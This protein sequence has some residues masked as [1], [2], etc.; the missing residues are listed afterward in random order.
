MTKKKRTVQICVV[1]AVIIIAIV[2]Y[3]FLSP[4]VFAWAFARYA[5]PGLYVKSVKGRLAGPIELTGLIYNSPRQEVRIN[6]LRAN[7]SQLALFTLRFEITNLE[8]SGVQIN[9]KSVP[10]VPKKK[11]KLPQIHMP[12]IKVLIDK[13]LVQNILYVPPPSGKNKPTLINR[14]DLSAHT[15]GNTL[16]VR[17]LDMVAPRYSFAAN[18]RVQLNN[19]Y[20]ISIKMAWQMAMANTPAISGTGSIEGSLRKRLCVLQTIAPPYPVK[21]DFTATDLLGT[22]AWNGFVNWQSIKIPASGPTRLITTGRFNTNGSIKKYVFGMN[23]DLLVQNIHRH[24]RITMKGNGNRQGLHLENFSADL[25]Y[26]KM[27]ANGK[28]SWKPVKSWDFVLSATGLD[29]GQFAPAWKGNISFA[30]ATSGKIPGP[31]QRDINFLLKNLSGNLK[32]QPVSGGGQIIVK[33]K[34]YRIPRLV[35][36]L[37]KASAFASGTIGKVWKLIWRLSAAD[38][39]VLMP[40]AKGAIAA[41]GNLSGPRAKPLAVA[42]FSG[43]GIQYPGMAIKTVRANMRIDM[44]EKTASRLNATVTGAAFRGHKISLLRLSGF[45][46]PS[47]NRITLLIAGRAGKNSLSLALAGGLIKKAWDGKMERLTITE[48][49]HRTWRLK[50]TASIKAGKTEMQLKDLCIISGPS[51]ACLSADYKKGLAAE[52]PPLA[53]QAHFN[54]SRVQLALFSPLLPPGASVTGQFGVNGDIYY[55]TANGI[56]GGMDLRAQNGTMEYVLQDQAARLPFKNG[57]ITLHTAREKAGLAATLFMKADFMPSK[58][59]SAGGGLESK[60]VITMRAGQTAAHAGLRGYFRMLIPNLGLLPAIIPSV[61]NASGH[62]RA[63]INLSGTLKQPNVGGIMSLENTSLT[64]PTLGITLTNSNLTATGSGENRFLINGMFHSGKGQ[65]QLKGD[66]GFQKLKGVALNM[67]VKGQN[68]Q[69]VKRPDADALISPDLTLVMQNGV[70]RASGSLTIPQANVKPI[71]VPSAVMPSPDVVIMQKRQGAAA[72][73]TFSKFY[74]NIKVIL[75]SRIFFNGF[76]LKSRISGSIA[77]RE[78]PQR[79]PTGYGQL[80]MSQGNYIAY[81]QTLKID[82]GK[83]LFAGPVDNPGLDIRATRT[84][85]NIVAGIN[86]AGTLKTPKFTIFSRPPMDQADALSYLVLGKPMHSSSASQ[87]NKLYNAATTLG[88]AGGGLLA[89][90]IGGFFGIKHVKVEKTAGPAKARLFLGKYLSPRLYVGY[91]IGIFVPSSIFR[92]RYS[93]TRSWMVQA[94]SGAETGFDML[95]KLRW[96]GGK[97]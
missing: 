60:L 86:V 94:E 50:K 16:Y 1:L 9:A 17:K 13:A 38:I 36:H 85:D 34:D 7:W 25:P 64:V 32:G 53:A 8:A 47:A 55:S 58:A 31:G 56:S 92:V 96:G 77:M 54:A 84:V 79:P 33:N 30:A 82:R 29:P 80:V 69:A 37:G 11:F 6:D 49:G 26:G 62:I 10:K 45:G 87:G 83:L 18:G 27:R 90:R 91:G 41:N 23:A 66:A 52:N 35:I 73:K 51:N 14:I 39:S 20:P 89:Q 63:N 72:K 61:S 78:M 40:Q 46:K 59:G 67:T 5:P 70:T 2:F 68:F 48:E 93:V 19:D 24:G 3:I 95:Y 88:I 71:S 15:S 97:K 57:V 22:P 28:A 74:A 4:G 12:P 21:M 81:K 76:G 75:G 43:A 44:S 65:I 42:R